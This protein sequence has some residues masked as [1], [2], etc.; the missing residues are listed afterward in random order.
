MSDFLSANS[1]IRQAQQTA[2]YTD[3][4][5][6]QKIKSE[7]DK[8]V[9]LQKVA[10]QFESMFVSMLFK[11]MRQANAVFEEGNMGHS[12]A[13]KTYRDM[14][15][16][17]LS[18]NISEGRGMGIADMVYRQLKG[19]H[20]RQANIQ[21]FTL[22]NS[23]TLTGLS[24]Y[25]KSDNTEAFKRTESQN[26]EL[27]DSS[28]TS[29]SQTLLNSQSSLNTSTSL[30][31]RESFNK[32]ESLKAVNNP[33]VSVK[34]PADFANT[35]LPIVKKITSATGLDPL[36][37]VAQAALETGW[38]KYMVKDALGQSSHNLFNIKADS[39][40]SGESVGTQTL[41]YREGIAQKET[42]RFRRYDSIEEGVRDFVHFI[43]NNPR[44][45]KALENK[46]SPN[47]FIQEL[48]HAGYATDPAYA[49][50]VQSVYATIKQSLLVQ[51]PQ[52]NP[53]DVDR[54]N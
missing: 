32:S 29:Y 40:W 11:G 37:M 17:Q 51:E 19:N 7:G 43:H 30:N 34:S 38:G 22:D 47:D 2:A 44:Y 53:L 52:T 31:T 26:T 10:K 28:A 42:A 48:Q 13:E 41:E 23:Q 12:N 4:N 20:Q 3:L 1:H 27:P 46:H 39:R 49:Q 35:L 18:L 45:T 50:K 36:M 6:L 15:D 8:D 54:V 21:D 14:H 24:P 33:L 25:A 5:S 9:A 16:Q